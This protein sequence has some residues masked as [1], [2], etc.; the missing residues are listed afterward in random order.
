MTLTEKLDAVMREQSLLPNT[1]TCYHGWVKAFYRHC[2]T[3]AS[4]WSPEL[5]RDW[6]LSLH[7]ADYSPTSRKQAL[8]AVLF[9]FRHVL[10]RD[11]GHL[12]LPPM[13]RVRQT[14]RTVPSRAFLRGCAG[15]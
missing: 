5:V 8:C 7:H 9:V 12:D 13:P 15:R 3:P 10:K 14:L 6:L 11:L 1:R 2:Q 4:A